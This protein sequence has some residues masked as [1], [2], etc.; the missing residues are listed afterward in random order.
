MSISRPTPAHIIDI[1]DDYSFEQ[2]PPYARDPPAYEYP[3]SY[4]EPETSL[5]T[6]IFRG[7][8]CVA[9]VSFIS[10][11][12]A[13]SATH[14]AQRNQHIFLAISF[15][16][17]VFAIW[18]LLT[19]CH[20]P[21]KILV[22]SHCWMH[23]GFSFMFLLCVDKF[24]VVFSFWQIILFAIISLLHVLALI[25]LYIAKRIQKSKV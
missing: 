3:P 19:L 14:V 4:H 18:F 12:S 22:Y 24:S 8:V 16:Y 6:K 10:Y 17:S 13:F 9:I 25:C 7:L 5:T 15:T 2:V 23:A 20:V 1:P 21:F 11:L